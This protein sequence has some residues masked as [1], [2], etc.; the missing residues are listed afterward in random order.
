MR[1]TLILCALALFL[2]QA[3]TQQP[4]ATGGGDPTPAARLDGIDITVGEVDAWIKDELFRQA[5]NDGEESKLH[6][7]RSQA[8]NNIINE[9][10]VEREARIRGIDSD[11]L[12]EDEASRRMSVG[13]AE[14]LEFWERNKAGM[15]G[16]DFAAAAAQIR[17][18]LERQKGPQAAR[19]FVQELR[20]DAEIEVL[21]SIPRIQVAASGPA[22]GPEDAPVTIVEFSDY[23][24][25]FCA[26][27]EPIISEV[28]KRYEGKVRFVYRHFPLDSIHKQ[29]R[30]ASEAAACADEQGKFW[31]YHALLFGSGADLSAAGLESHAEAVEADLEA[32]RTCV[33]ERRYKATV[34][35]DVAEGRSAGVTGTPAFF[36]NGIVLKG[37]QPVDEFVRIID[38]ELAAGAAETAEGADNDAG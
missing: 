13:E 12:M 37:A 22:M 8:A 21:I 23:E 24:C 6:E 18:H 19:E 3:C 4:A 1:P 17:R 29:A 38:A 28:L 27:A 36:V 20:K 30:G 9:R 11:Q 7:L 33:E 26:R 5:S 32:F 15:G 34:E 14:V 25:P 16:L 2:A 35:A 31:P 10:L